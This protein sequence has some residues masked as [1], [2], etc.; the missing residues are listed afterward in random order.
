MGTVEEAYKNHKIWTYD[1][2][3]LWLRQKKT[4]YVYFCKTCPCGPCLNRRRIAW[5]TIGVGHDALWELATDNGDGPTDENKE[6]IGYAGPGIIKYRK[7]KIWGMFNYISENYKGHPIDSFEE[8]ST[9]IATGGITPI[10]SGI[11]LFHGVVGE[12]GSLLENS[13]GQGLPAAVYAPTTKPDSIIPDT[14]TWVLEEGC[15][16]PTEREGYFD[17][18]FPSI[19]VYAYNWPFIK[20]E[21]DS[22]SKDN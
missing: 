13:N 19:T 10:F 11:P 5:K 2:E 1:K 17:I 15:R 9:A 20:Q 16:V 14:V 7:D 8:L 12:D 18:V 4:N 3:V 21:D 6:D 22:N